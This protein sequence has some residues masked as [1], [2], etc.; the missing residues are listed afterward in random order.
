[1]QCS[2]GGLTT[3]GLDKATFRVNIVGDAATDPAIA[4]AVKRWWGELWV[5]VLRAHK[6]LVEPHLFGPNNDGGGGAAYSSTP[7]VKRE[8][9]GRYERT[10]T[11]H[12]MSS[13]LN[14]P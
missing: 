1:M 10:S 5:P 8:D 4:A 7:F 3:V 6:D 9:S 13:T 14:G 12:R 11:T 2:S